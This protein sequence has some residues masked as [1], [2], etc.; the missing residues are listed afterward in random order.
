MTRIVRPALLVV[1]ACLLLLAPGAAQA[2]R[3]RVIVTTVSPYWGY[4]RYSYAAALFG[5]ADYTRA[6]A[7]WRF[8]IQKAAQEREKTRRMKLETRRIELEHMKWERNFQW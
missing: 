2:Q 1:V 6:D 4:T 8:T 3:R 7:Q 5:L